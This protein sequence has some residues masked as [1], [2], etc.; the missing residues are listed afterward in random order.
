MKKTYSASITPLTPQKTLDEKSLFR[1]IDRNVRH[2]LSGVFLLGSMGE[3]SQLDNETRDAVIR[4]GT[5]AMA[6]RGEIL[7]GIHSTGLDLTLKNMERIADIPFSSYVITLPNRTSLIDPMTY[8]LTV[9]DKADRPVY[10]YHHPG[11]NGIRFGIDDFRRLA[12]HPRFAGLKNSA[13]DMM[14]R[15]E[16]LMLKQECNFIQLEGNEWAMDEALMLGCDGVLSGGGALTSK[17]MVALARAVDQ[18]D[19]T[20]AMHIQ[21][22]L[23]KVFHL[24]YGKSLNSVWAGEK[25]ALKVLGVIDSEMTLVECAET[26][27]TPARRREIETGLEQFREELD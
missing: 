2:G 8:L 9:L 5:E 1:V 20:K 23:I 12:Q 11:V 7:A 19:F 24:I 15:K 4:V 17:M 6:G 14:L 21:H 10:Y 25:Y 3:W 16:L 22:R 27:L 13:S 18:Q 26:L